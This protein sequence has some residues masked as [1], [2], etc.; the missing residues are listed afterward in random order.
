LSGCPSGS[1]DFPFGILRTRRLLG[2]GGY[3]ASLIAELVGPSGSVVCVEIDP[4]VHARTERF[5]AETGYAGRVRLALGDGAHGAPGH[6]IPEDGFDAIIVTVASNDLPRPWTSQ[7]A[8]GGH[9]VVPLRVGGFTRAVGLQKEDSVLVSTE[10]SPCGCVPMRGTGRWD[11]IPTPSG[12]PATGSAGRTPRLPRSTAWT[13]PSPEAGGELWTGVRVRG[14]ESLE[15]LR[16]W[17]ATSLGG[18][19]RM[20]GG[21]ERQ[22]PVRLPKRP[23]AEAIVLGRSLAC[24][25]TER[26]EHDRANGTSTWEFG[27]Q[28]FGPDGKTAADTMAAAVH[29][30]DRE[31]PERVTP[32]L[33]VM[34]ADTPDSALPTGEI[35]E[36]THC[37]IVVAWPGR[38]EGADS[39]VGRNTARGRS[40]ER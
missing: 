4:Y 3:N 14:G 9:L 24:L 28:G 11:D 33:T 32:R 16:L 27:V 26:R 1:G 29:T 17:L 38:D 12:T 2:G 36:K 22:G 31:L 34:P 25:M 20:D 18:F 23:G 15:D 8:E 40:E 30:W 21:P 5:L 6:L 39:A 7:L 35:V 19:C 10:I 13:A 37:R